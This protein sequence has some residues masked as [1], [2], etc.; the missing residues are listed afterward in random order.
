MSWTPTGS[1]TARNEATGEALSI[2]VLAD[3]TA[4]WRVSGNDTSCRIGLATWLDEPIGM[5]AVQRG[6]GDGAL[7][8]EQAFAT[9]G[10]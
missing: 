6:G 7:T 9:L 4:Y 8:F 1:I 10:D 2:D 5:P 3:G